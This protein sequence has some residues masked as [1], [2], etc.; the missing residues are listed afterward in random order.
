[1]SAP[2]IHLQ[3]TENACRRDAWWL[4]AAERNTHASS[5]SCRPI[6]RMF[7]ERECVASERGRV[8]MTHFA[9]MVAEPDRGRHVM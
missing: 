8:I 7:G 3:A 2:T 5:G 9:Q 6:V 1:L 4:A